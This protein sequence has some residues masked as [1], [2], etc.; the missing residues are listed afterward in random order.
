MRMNCLLSLSLLCL[1]GCATAP[2]VATGPATQPV[3]SIRRLGSEAFRFGGIQKEA[4]FSRDG[5]S[6]LIGGGP[7]GR[8][9]AWDF[10]TGKPTTL[11]AFGVAV[12]LESPDGRYLIYPS[13]KPNHPD[14][15]ACVDARTGKRLYEL[16]IHSGMMG[17]YAISPDSKHLVVTT[18]Y[19]GRGGLGSFHSTDHSLR[20]HNLATGELVF[21]ENLGFRGTNRCVTGVAFSP[22]NHWLVTYSND[23]ILRVWDRATLKIVRQLPGSAG[24]DLG[25][26]PNGKWLLD[27]TEFGSQVVDVETWTNIQPNNLAIAR[28][29]AFSPDGSLLVGGQLRQ[30]S[31]PPPGA[32]V[33]Y[34][35]TRQRSIRAIPAHRQALWGVAFA[36]DGKTVL[37]IGNDQALHL[38]DVATWQELRHTHG[39]W[40]QITSLSFSS[41]SH[42]L[43][44]SD[45]SGIVYV[46]DVTSGDVI[47]RIQQVGAPVY[48]VSLAADGGTVSVFGAK[49]TFNSL[50]SLVWLMDVS[51]GRTLKELPGYDDY[52]SN[53]HTWLS[54]DGERLVGGDGETLVIRSVN[55]AEAPQNLHGRYLPELD[56]I[57]TADEYS[58]GFG[59]KISLRSQA[60]GKKLV[61][62]QGF[63]PAAVT[64][65][66]KFWASTGDNIGELRLGEVATGKVLL[67]LK[68]PV[69]S[70]A[71]SPDGKTLAIARQEGAIELRDT[72]TAKVTREY[73]DPQGSVSQLAFSP[74]GKT[75]ASGGRAGS[76]VLWAVP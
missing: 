48:S 49:G 13:P 12:P 47:Q 28:P 7:D 51:S 62:Y 69:K 39:H 31:E 9:G 63:K 74:D 53:W 67:H 8:T 2:H 66:L 55:Q 60:T 1:A 4:R 71:F 73:R 18:M 35:V 72:R 3:G 26:S 70:V 64:R 11:P 17:R 44:T 30:T 76:V 6:I 19:L 36:P 40:G 46:W 61:D 32:L 25:F 33:V 58:T 38:W 54:N 68:E 14:G 45:D 24:G 27:A 23:S 52:D 21:R 75:L 20:L 41:D 16:G 57:A 10:A 59:G 5:R 34:D 42:R 29:A 22:D 43:A 50:G 65:D 15:L 37:S 56:A